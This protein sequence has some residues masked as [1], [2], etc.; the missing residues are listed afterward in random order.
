MS[1]KRVI[2]DTEIYPNYFLLIAKDIDTKEIFRFEI[3][4]YV[5][6]RS[7]L[8]HFLR[9]LSVMI[10]FNNLNFD[11]PLL[12]LLLSLLN[13]DFNMVGSKIVKALK[14]KADQII[15]DKP[16]T[17]RKKPVIPQIDLFKIHHFDNKS[18][19][20]SLKYLEFSMRMHKI[21]ELPFPP[22]KMLTR[23][24]MEQVSDYCINGDVTATEELYLKS[25]EH[26]EMREKLSE[27]YGVNFIN[28][29]DPKIGETILIKIISE[30]TKRDELGQTKRES[31]AIE[32]V[33]F[34]YVRF[35][36][37]EFDSVYRW[38]KKKVI[39]ETKG[40]F[41]KIDLDTLEDVAKYANME[42]KMLVK[43]KLKTLNVVL[44]GLQV[45]FGTGGIHAST[46]PGLYEKTDDLIIEDI[47]VESYYP[48]L[49]IKNK[50]FPMHLGEE[51]C[52]IYDEIFH[53]RRKYAKNTPENKGLKLALN[54]AYGKSNSV[55]SKLYDPQYTMSITINGQ[56]L[57]CM[58]VEWLK[59]IPN[60]K[61][62]QMNTD[63]VTVMYDRK[64]K[65]RVDFI[66][67]RWSEMTQ[68]TLEHAFFDKMIIRDVNNYLAIKSDGTT[69]RKGAFEH[70]RELYRNNSMLV[71]PKAIEQY[72]LNGIKPEDF[73][74]NHTDPFD[75][76]KATK[77]TASSQLVF[78]FEGEQ[79]P[80]QRI[81]RY[82]VGKIGGKLI[83]LMPPLKDKTELREMN[84]ESDHLCVP[85]NTVTVKRSKQMRSNLDYNYY[86][87]EVYKIINAIAAHENIENDDEDMEDDNLSD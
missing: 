44:D 56:F 38:M 50:L 87:N 47:D 74:I 64:Y 65:E 2:Y 25:I 29:N 55:Y 66:C 30:R 83:K 70:N 85:I 18:K 77:L 17:P 7:Q 27:L 41:T 43:G 49:G 37:P 58:L 78:R 3:S 51:F 52:T 19:M 34:P 20:T 42:K 4:P 67:K 22:N 60:I 6:N 57:L 32:D 62:L 54:G 9:S 79:H 23:E 75:F 61:I 5:D 14:T 28:Y 26:I 12:D 10:G 16:F 86:I 33:I 46:E 73:I 53:L 13:K 31:I 82:Y 48:N 81:T 72:Y 76:M 80:M 24:E 35:M 8:I 68:L 71:V 63:G 40:V 39:Q 21:Q 45:N 36:T 15:R 59:I 1:A 11:Y 69:K 84:I